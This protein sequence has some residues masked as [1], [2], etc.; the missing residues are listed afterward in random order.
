M[1]N[2][3]AATSLTPPPSLNP[4]QSDNVQKVIIVTVCS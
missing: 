4:H 1:S 3:P 2:T